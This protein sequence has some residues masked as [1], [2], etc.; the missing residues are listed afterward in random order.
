MPNETES[1][2]NNSFFAWSVKN[3]RTTVLSGDQ[4]EMANREF[5]IMGATLIRLYKMIYFS[6]EKQAHG[7]NYELRRQ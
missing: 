2:R 6:I 1:S 7:E 4:V 5:P 3:W